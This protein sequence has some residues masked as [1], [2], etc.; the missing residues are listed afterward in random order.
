MKHD[1]WESELR[2]QILKNHS[3]LLEVQAHGFGLEV[4]ELFEDIGAFI[5][6]NFILKTH[7]DKL[8]ADAHDDGY[9]EARAEVERVLGEMK[10]PERALEDLKGKKFSEENI[11]ELMR[12]GCDARQNAVL[13]DVRRAL[14]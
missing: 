10:K 4:D 9:K 13:D 8:I 2:N 5:R 3:A 14:Q 6:N 1:D 11:L 7:A 12:R